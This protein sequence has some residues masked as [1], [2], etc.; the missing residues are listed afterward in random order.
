MTRPTIYLGRGTTPTDR[1]RS[2]NSICDF[3]ADITSER[4]DPD[5]VRTLYDHAES[6]ASTV[7]WKNDQYL[8]MNPGS[9]LARD[10]QG[11]DEPA[12]EAFLHARDTDTAIVIVD[13]LAKINIDRVETL[14]TDYVVTVHDATHATTLY[15]VHDDRL[16]TALRRALEVLTGTAEHADAL[17][18][19]IDW[20]GG[21][22]PLGTTS[23][24]GCL[25]PDED[26]DTVCHT[27]QHVADGR[28]SKSDAAEMLDCARK[29]ID[30]AL[31]RRELYRLD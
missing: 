7:A 23:E 6:N 3:V 15:P 12:R 22:P 30:N 18:A 24:G 19:G 5:T 14:L 9:T 8:Y 17:L 27:I 16:P 26:Y 21:R 11:P 10:R 25:A 28:M 1:D 2:I 13:T 4:T 29:T 31:E 20:K